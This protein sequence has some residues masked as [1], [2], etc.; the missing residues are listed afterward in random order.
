MDVVQDPNGQVRLSQVSSVSCR[1]SIRLGLKIFFANPLARISRKENSRACPSSRPILHDLHTR[2]TRTRPFDA[3]YLILCNHA[4]LKSVPLHYN[5]KHGTHAVF[6][7]QSNGRNRQQAGRVSGSSASQ[8][9]SSD[10]LLRMR[11]LHR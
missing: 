9:K 8:S 1:P 6:G 3:Q 4:G 10:T 11:E 5:N 7:V 2:T